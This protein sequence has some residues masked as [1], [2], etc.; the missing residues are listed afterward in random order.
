MQ[1]EDADAYFGRVLRD[2]KPATRTGRAAAAD[3]ALPSRLQGPL[4]VP[5]GQRF[6]RSHAGRRDRGR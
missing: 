2:A 6:C 3:P 4:Q 1:P 5:E